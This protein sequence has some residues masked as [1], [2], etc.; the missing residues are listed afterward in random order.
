MDNTYITDLMIGVAT[1]SFHHFDHN[2]GTHENG[3]SWAA[4]FKTVRS[5]VVGVLID[6]AT[7][8]LSFY[9]DGKRLRSKTISGIPH[10][11]LYPAVSVYHRVS[12]EA[13]CLL[14][15]MTRFVSD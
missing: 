8:S 9:L 11:T 6:H 5:G 3:G 14:T 2:L 4:S 10:S 7:R 15:V 12:R 1:E 13:L